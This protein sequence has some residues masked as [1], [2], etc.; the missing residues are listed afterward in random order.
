MYAQAPNASCDASEKTQSTGDS[1]VSGGIRDLLNPIWSSSFISMKSLIHISC[2]SMEAHRPNEDQ[3]ATTLAS[4]FCSDNECSSES[5][6][7]VEAGNLT[8]KRSFG[9][10]YSKVY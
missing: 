1:G 7:V 8:K 3:S 9:H 2:T 10:L 6:G 4:L 5:N